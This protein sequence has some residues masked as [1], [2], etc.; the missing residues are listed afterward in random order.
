MAIGGRLR[1]CF[2]SRF[3]SFDLSRPATPATEGGR[4]R[5]ANHNSGDA[6]VLGREG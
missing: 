2:G 3:S 4:A 6:D 1:R 5:L